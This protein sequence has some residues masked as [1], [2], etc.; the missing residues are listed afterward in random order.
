MQNLASKILLI[1]IDR[2]HLVKELRHRV[3]QTGLPLPGWRPGTQHPPASP[4]TWSQNNTAS[5][6]FMMIKWD[7][8][9]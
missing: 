7:D 3:R 6:D 8:V 4:V 2:E 1:S 5:Q 9:C